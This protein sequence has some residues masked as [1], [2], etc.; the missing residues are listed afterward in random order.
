MKLNIKLNLNQVESNLMSSLESN[1]IELDSAQ[2]FN[3]STYLD[4]IKKHITPKTVINNHKNILQA[5][6]YDSDDSNNYWIVLDKN[7]YFVD[8]C[9]PMTI[10]LDNDSTYENLSTVEIKIIKSIKE[11]IN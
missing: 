4:L 9:I 6:K 7:F 3:L 5:C 1:D 10:D 8:V 11:F 2:L